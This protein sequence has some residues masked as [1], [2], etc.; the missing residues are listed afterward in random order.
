[1]NWLALPHFAPRIF[2]A[3]RFDALQTVDRLLLLR[4]LQQLRHHLHPAELRQFVA[5][6]RVGLAHIDE[7]SREIDHH[8][9]VQVEKGNGRLLGRRAKQRLGRRV[10]R[11][12]L[13]FALQKRHHRGDAFVLAEKRAHP[14]RTLRDVDQ[15]A[16]RHQQQLLDLRRK[17]LLGVRS[18]MKRLHAV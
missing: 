8:F 10:H 18:A 11:G 13:Q 3:A 15:T 7:D 4:H 12:T 9:A 1:M 17:T 16:R 14:T 2:L 5:A 6:H